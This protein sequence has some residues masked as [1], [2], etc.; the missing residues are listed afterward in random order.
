MIDREDHGRVRV[1]RFNH[2]PANVLT[3]ALLERLRKE[4]AE[5][6]GDDGVRCLVLASAL[7]KYFST[8]LDLG[9]LSGS[10][11]GKRSGPFLALIET[12]RTIEAFPKPIVASLNGSAIL[13]GWILAM[14]CDFR[15]LAREQGRIALSEVRMGLSPTRA[16]IQKLTSIGKDPSLVKAMVLRG[17]TLRAEEALSGGFVDAVFPGAKLEDAVMK[18]AKA[19]AK[20]AP[21]AYAS[22]KKSLSRVYGESH[23]AL[24]KESIEDFDEL[25]ADPLTAEG[26]SAMKEKRRPRWEK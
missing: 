15:Y 9:E 8:G 7:P 22:V 10:G 17:K 11:E 5:A 18:E 13:G 16:L 21:H 14:A 26:L 3:M 2:P 24:W 6:A 1:L 19:L 4:F 23:D 20:M 25:F 12:F